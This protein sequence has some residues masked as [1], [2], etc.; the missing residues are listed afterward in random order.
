MFLEMLEEIAHETEAA[1][2]SFGGSLGDP[3][4]L[5]LYAIALFDGDS[6]DEAGMVDGP[7]PN[8]REMLSTYPRREGHLDPWIVRIE[9]GRERKITRLFRVREDEGSL[10]WERMAE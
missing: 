10:S 4:A 1:R 5:P 2:N 3:E 6:K 7:T 9:V 8:L